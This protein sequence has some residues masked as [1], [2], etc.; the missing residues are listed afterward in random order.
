MLM[1]D[2]KVL[3][4]VFHFHIKHSQQNEHTS[5]FL[6][7]LFRAF[8]VIIAIIFQHMHNFSPFFIIVQMTLLSTAR[9]Q[10]KKY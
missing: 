10:D 4:C 9:I 5:P 3:F 1:V 7:V 8:S 6:R 2:L